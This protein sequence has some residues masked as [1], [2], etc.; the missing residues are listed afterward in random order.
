M[1][2]SS[3]RLAP[4]SEQ[5]AMFSRPPSSPIMAKRKPSPSSPMRFSTGTRAE[6]KL[7][8]AVGWLRQPIFRS[9]AP[10]LRPGVSFSTTR[11]ETPRAPA[12]PVRTMTT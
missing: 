8:M 2:A 12:S 3:A 7:T 11:A 4:P 10:K 9:G 6:S 5:E 1:A